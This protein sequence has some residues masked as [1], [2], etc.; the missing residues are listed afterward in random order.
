MPV[1]APRTSRASAAEPATPGQPLA[2]RPEGRFRVPAAGTRPAGQHVADVPADAA[3][4]SRIP[5][6][7][8]LHRPA[9]R[10]AAGRPDRPR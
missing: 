8:T 4:T 6:A 3:P 2:G 10:P 5:D 1:P 7:A 9:D